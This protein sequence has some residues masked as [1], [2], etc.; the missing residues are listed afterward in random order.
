VVAGLRRAA[1]KWFWREK[2]AKFKGQA[3]ERLGE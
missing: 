1:E 2:S 3:S